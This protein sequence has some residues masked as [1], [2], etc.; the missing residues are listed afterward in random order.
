MNRFQATKTIRVIALILALVGLL[1]ACQP[2]G[3]VPQAS[4]GT[5]CDGEPPEGCSVFTVA[6]GDRVFFPCALVLKLAQSK[7]S[8]T[9]V[10]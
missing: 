4:C 9:G 2:G 8:L 3:A 5:F 10:V 6:K 7:S 1:A